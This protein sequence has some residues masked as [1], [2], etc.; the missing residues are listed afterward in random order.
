MN[1]CSAC[2]TALEH[3]IPPGDDR[4]RFVC[5]SCHTVH[6]QNPRVVTGCLASWNDSVLLCRRAIEPRSGYWTLPAG[7]LELGETSVEGA[8]RE[9]WEEARARVEV[10]GLYSVFNLPHVNQV[11]LMFRARLRDLDFHPGP[12]SEEVALF[13]QDEVPWGDI[14]FGTVLHSLQFYFRDRVRDRFPVH[15]GTIRRTPAGFHLEVG[16][17]DRAESD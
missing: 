11:Y 1:F 16:P 10:L 14:A 12:E 2:G 3:R 4:L 17:D 15:T 9:T 13:E 8:V 5:P 7:F 6:Y